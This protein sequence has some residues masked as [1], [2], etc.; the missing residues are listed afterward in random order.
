M[1]FKITGL[2]ELQ[3][4]LKQMEK[5]A[6]ELSQTKQVSF[7]K[8]FSASF[9]RKYTSFSSIDEFLNAGGFD[10]QSQEAFEA[11]PEEELD[12][13][14]AN[15]TNFKNWEDMLGEAGTQYALKK[16]GF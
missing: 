1:S 11:I 9:M 14:I 5:A 8:L 2:T 15:T 3:K 12:K 6:K 4:D 7:D 16:L 10:A 13:Y